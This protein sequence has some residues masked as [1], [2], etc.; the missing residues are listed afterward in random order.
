MKFT[1]RVGNWFYFHDIHFTGDNT[2]YNCKILVEKFQNQ[3]NRYIVYDEIGIFQNFEFFDSA[4][5]KRIKNPKRMEL[6]NV[7]LKEEE[8]VK[9]IQA[10]EQKEIENRKRSEIEI[11]E[12]KS[13]YN[14]LFDAIQQGNIQ[15]LIDFLEVNCGGEIGHIDADKALLKFIGNDKVSKAFNSIQK[16]YA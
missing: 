7:L 12:Q 3:K 14:T 13:K 10:I 9:E 1:K 2:T 11:N 15:S 8:I 16:W 5:S 6:F 4:T